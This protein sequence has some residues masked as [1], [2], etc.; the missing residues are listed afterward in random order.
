[1]MVV[2]VAAFCASFSGSLTGGHITGLLLLSA[3]PIGLIYMQPDLGT[4][5][6]FI[7]VLLGVLAVGGAR[8]RHLA[9]LAAI[10]VPAVVLV[11][12]LGVL[13]PYQLDRFGA[14]LDQQ[15]S[16]Q[17]VA[18]DASPAQYNLNQSKIAIGSGGITGKGLLKAT[19]TNL[20]ALP[21]QSTALHFTALGWGGG[22]L[23]EKKGEALLTQGRTVVVSAW[24][25]E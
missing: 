15:D 16:S 1:M 22:V 23:A 8:P 14:F 11:L 3:I 21:D 2:C 17:R 25:S 20:A 12:Q 19:Q 7:A 6:V 5:L 10:G 9:I 13:Q 18:Y 24:A 4:A